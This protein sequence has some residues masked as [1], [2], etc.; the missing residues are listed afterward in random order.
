MP[1]APRIA[2]SL[3]AL[4]LVLLA[5]GGCGGG[6]SS[7]HSSAPVQAPAP[8]PTPAPAKAPTT[9]RPPRGGRAQLADLLRHELA[10]TGPDSGAYVYDLT[11]G[12]EVFSERAGVGRPPASVEKLF[13]SVAL[14]ARL[15]PGARLRTSVLGSGSLGPGGAW[16]GDL[17]LRGGGDPTLASPAFRRIYQ[18]GYGATLSDLV[19]QLR[20][21]GIRSV[22]GSVIG[23]ASHYSSERGGPT[24]KYGPDLG[25]LGGELSAL[26]YNHGASGGTAK[27]AATPGAYAAEQFALAL[28]GAGVEVVPAPATARAPADARVLAGVSS[29]PL[30]ELL[31]LMNVPSDDFYA[32]MLTEELGARF[33]ATGSIPDGA[34]VIADAIATY[35]IHPTVADGSGLSRSDRSSPR[36]VGELLR[37]MAADQS[38]GPVLSASLPLVGVDG[39][40]R[41]IA[42]H[43]VAQGRCVA[44]TG[45]LDYVTNLAGYCDGAG[46]QQIAFAIFDDG[47]PNQTALATEGRMVADIVRLDAGRS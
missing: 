27:G 44:K 29:P 7:S 11:T 15:G 10:L 14:L 41:R 37:A 1:V 23:D 8:A 16:R 13:T 24:T 17:Y 40:T 33:G 34:Q 4:G 26:T 35:G 5:L 22:S 9:G 42:R 18:S 2:S 32:E 19:S 6:S 20:S 36:E 39:T 45:T 46:H 21:A 30:S 25:D 31:R 47:P 43:T 3:G 38:L 28:H 12:R